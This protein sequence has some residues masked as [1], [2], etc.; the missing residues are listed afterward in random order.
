M[1]IERDGALDGLWCARP[2]ALAE[3]RKSAFPLRWGEETILVNRPRMETRKL[4][5]LKTY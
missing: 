3:S 2:L 5:R 1:V 4:P